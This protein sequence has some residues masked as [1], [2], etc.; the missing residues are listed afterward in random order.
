MGSPP[1]GLMLGVPLHTVA[2]CVALRSK[3]LKTWPS[4]TLF[5]PL[6][7]PEEIAKHKGPPVFTQEE[8]YKMVQA[9][10]WVDEVVP[11]APYVTTLETLDE[12]NCDFCVHGSEWAGPGGWWVRVYWAVR[13]IDSFSETAGLSS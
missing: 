8:R 4:L 13:P 1:C 5:R 2:H 6:L 10:K 7:S 11:A 3:P 9:I 12:H